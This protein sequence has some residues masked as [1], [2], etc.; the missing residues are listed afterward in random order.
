MRSILGSLFGPSASSVGRSP[1]DDFWYR[2][3]PSPTYSGVDVTEET[4]LTYSTV[5]ACVSKIA[6]TI[7]TLPVHVYKRLPNGGKEP[8]PGHPLQRL[9]QM[10]PNPEMSAVSAR[11]AFLTNCLL[12]GNGIME[13]QENHGGGVGAL[14]P[15]LTRFLTLKRDDNDMLYFEYNLPG[16]KMRILRFDQVVNL[17]AFSTDGIV[18]KT[19]IQLARESV[20]LGLAARQFQSSFL[21][22]GAS[23]SMV[24]MHPGPKPMSEPA[25]MRLI[26]SFNEKH[27]GSGN[28]G[29]TLLLEEDTKVQTVGMSFKDAQYLELGHALKE[30]ICGMYD[31]PL[32]MIQD[33]KRAT[34]S[35]N[36]QKAIDWVVGSLLPWCVRIETAMNNALL[37]GGREYYLKHELSGLMRGDLTARTDSYTKMIRVGTSLNE[38]RKL[39]DMDGIGPEGDRRFVS[40]DLVPL[41]KIDEVI[42]SKRPATGSPPSEPKE[43]G[44]REDARAM[45][46]ALSEANARGNAQIQQFNE[47]MIAIDDRSRERDAKVI[48]A[49]DRGRVA[50][51]AAKASADARF[52]DA[53]AERKAARKEQGE[54]NQ[55]L[56][57]E[58]RAVSAGMN[59]AVVQAL[60]EDRAERKV[61][62]ESFR[63]V[64]LDATQRIVTKEVKAI[65]SAWKRHAKNGTIET[66]LNRVEKFY[67]E[68]E[69]TAREAVLPVLQSCGELLGNPD[70]QAEGQSRLFAGQYVACSLAAVRDCVSEAPE[71]LPEEL[72]KWQ[73]SKGEE[74]AEGLLAKITD[75]SEP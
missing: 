45:V 41:D 74:L 49:V 32:S 20:G 38:I 52:S 59:S 31:V 26:N 19:P 14:W 27:E 17:A 36:E 43:P 69:D 72:T 29:K 4:A 70:S 33:D 47:V 11:E 12:W 1:T 75:G 16:K 51:E 71:R 5:Y 2:P 10:A 53:T 68:H 23:P 15:L 6:K 56:N 54:A 24:F 34:Y 48:E 60:R 65:E 30:D 50:G 7:A 67:G 9:W 3:V 58:V 28:A 40:A 57:K 46:A 64:M 62:A 37:D 55:S 18:G 22:N 39:E 44:D 73:Q 25:Y 42:E 66:F 35:N 63:P 61:T 8:A 13:I 21:K